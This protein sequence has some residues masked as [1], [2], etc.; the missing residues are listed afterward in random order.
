MQNIQSVTN[1]HHT[2]HKSS[3]NL[4]KG[5]KTLS[6]AYFN[7]S[8]R[9]WGKTENEFVFKSLSLMARYNLIDTKYCQ[10]PFQSS[11]DGAPISPYQ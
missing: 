9:Q 10:M 2:H 4:I 8:V 11:S 7:I 3:S 6:L 5:I 1:I